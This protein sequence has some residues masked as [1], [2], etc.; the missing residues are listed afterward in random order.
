M[1]R[2][3]ARTRALLRRAHFEMIVEKGYDAVTVED[4]CRA[5]DVGRS[6]FYAHFTGKD[7][8]HR[9]GLAT[10][11]V[12]LLDH[13]AAHGVGADG[14][15]LAFSRLMFEHARD[16]LDLYRALVGSRG[17]GA[18]LDS[19]RQILCEVVRRGLPATPA[20]PELAVQFIVGAYLAV[21]TWWLDAG[22]PIP[23]AEVDAH[24]QRLAR[25]GLA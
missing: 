12:Q 13:Q 17:G 22:L 16:H 2:R 5:A 11:R 7:D 1:D 25:K 20:P 6:T 23:P 15:Q 21:M 10:L 24:F 8:L 3:V 19:I 4:I 9:S 14:G 18:A